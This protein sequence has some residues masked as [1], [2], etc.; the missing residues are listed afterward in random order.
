LKKFLSGCA[1]F[2][3]LVVGV[4]VYLVYTFFYSLGHLPEGEFLD[5]ISS[6]NQTYTI[7]FYRVNGGAT[8]AYSIRGELVHNKTKKKENIYWE[9]RSDQVKASWVDEHTVVIN[10]H[11]LDVRKDTYDWR[12][13]K[14]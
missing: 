12:R 1:I 4:I 5:Q 13:E 2:L 14:N 9:Y 6:P 3:I 7:N 10:G 8:V 11:T